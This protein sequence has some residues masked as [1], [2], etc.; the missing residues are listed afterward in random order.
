VLQQAV[1]TSP[2]NRELLGA[3]GRALMDVGNFR[4]AD[5][6]LGRAHVPERPDWRILSAQGAVAD[7]LGE[8]DRAQGLY[9]A[10]L[11]INP[12]DPTV[13][14]NLG[15]SYA[16]T[17][18]LP[19]AERVLTDAARHPRADKRV[20]QN[21]MLVYGLQGRFPDA[22]RIAAQDLP[23][24]D[25]Q[26]AMLQLRQLVSQPNNWDR[27][28]QG[29]RRTQPARAAAA[30]RPQERTES[31]AERRAPASGQDQSAAAAED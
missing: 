4:Q 14:S 8:H 11:R 3:Y 17:R 28:R 26:R 21:L 19:E 13:L 2:N 25:V 20:R 1:I 29:E 30:Q 10:A 9:Q 31:R 23:P 22:E 16:L 27:L 5:E 7:Q 12:G 15:L 24:A 18:R 6:V